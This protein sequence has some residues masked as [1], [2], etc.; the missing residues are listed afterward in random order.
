ME[1]KLS[2][3]SLD[4][5]IVTCALSSPFSKSKAAG[6]MVKSLGKEMSSRLKGAREAGVEGSQ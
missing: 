3:E 6:A 2:P 1:T 4:H 5:Q